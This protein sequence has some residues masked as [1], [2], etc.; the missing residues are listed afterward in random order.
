MIC[1]E[2]LGVN[3]YLSYEDERY[4]TLVLRS[5][6]FDTVGYALDLDT[7][8]LQR[9]CICEARNSNECACGAWDLP[10]KEKNV[11]QP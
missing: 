10:K 1:G 4:P 2:E 3:V 6:A 9:V 11:P 7:G 8:E 5:K